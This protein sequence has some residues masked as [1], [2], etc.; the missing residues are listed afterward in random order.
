MGTRYRRQRKQ[1][2]ECAATCKKYLHVQ[3]E[4]AVGRQD[5]SGGITWKSIAEYFSAVH[6]N[7]EERQ[8]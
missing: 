5:S 2:M 4:N 3:A 1:L 8:H 7:R 6:K